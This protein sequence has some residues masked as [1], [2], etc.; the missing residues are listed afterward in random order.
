[1]KIDIYRA[2][3]RQRYV[4]GYNRNRFRLYHVTRFVIRS[5]INYI[6]KRRSLFSK[7]E[8]LRRYCANV[9]KYYI[10]NGRNRKKTSIRFFACCLHTFY[11]EYTCSTSFKFRNV[12]KRSASRTCVFTMPL[13]HAVTTRV[14]LSTLTQFHETVVQMLRSR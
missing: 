1:M 12:Y 10:Y 4:S 3:D 14:P 11:E 2:I 9:Y 6:S 13:C 5:K 8:I 7:S